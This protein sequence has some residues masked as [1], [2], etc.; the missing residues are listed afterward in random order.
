MRLPSKQY[1]VI[2][3]LCTT[4]ATLFFHGVAGFPVQASL[5]IALI[6]W[7]VIDGLSGLSLHRVARGRRR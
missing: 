6:L 4:V 1:T 5:A 2:A 7:A 3:L